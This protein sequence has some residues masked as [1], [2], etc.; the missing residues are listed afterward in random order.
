MTIRLFRWDDL[1][2]VVAVMN[3]YSKALVGAGDRTVE[4][5]ESIWHNP[6]NH[7]DRDCFVS[8]APDGHIDGFS[9]ADLLEN[10]SRAIGVYTVPPPNREAGQA[11]IEAA[12]AHFLRMAGDRAPLTMEWQISDQDTDGI[13]LLEAEGYQNVRAFYT[14]RILLA[15]PI[16]APPLPDGFTRRPFTPD[17]VEAL[18]EAKTE[19][20]RDHW[21]Q[22][23]MSLSEWQAD[24]AQ[25]DFDPTL[26]WVVLCGDD[27]AGMLLSR[28]HGPEAAWVGILGVKRAYRGRGLAHALLRQCFAEYQRRGWKRVSLGVDSDSLTNA[29]AVYRRAGMHIYTRQLFFHKTLRPAGEAEGKSLSG[30][31]LT[32]K[33]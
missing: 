29:V 33:C 16:D 14:M 20:F 2:A 12:Q 26:W 15:E 24:I 13:A 25:P 19:I 31:N 21:G 1:P 28:P 27:I 30:V 6:Y 32:K 18:Y 9:I 8:V 4:Q 3:A 22:G 7:P 17:Q 11:L 5:V 23:D 10:P